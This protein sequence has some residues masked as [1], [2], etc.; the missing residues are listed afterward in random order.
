L[1]S[2]RTLDT[3]ASFLAGELRRLG[4]RVDEIRSLPDH[5]PVLIRTIRELARG[6][7][8]LILTGG[9]G[10]TEDDRTRHA[11]ALAA[12]KPLR[13]H[14]PSLTAIEERFR[15]SGRTMTANNRTQAMFPAS[16]SPLP[17]ARGTAPGIRMRLGSCRLLAFPGVPHE[18]KA[19]WE[20]S[21]LPLSRELGRR[22]LRLRRLHVF[23][24]TESEVDRRMH[25]L[26]LPGRD[27]EVGLT[28][29][30]SVITV[31]LTSASR[32]RIARDETLLRRLLGRA[33]FG[34]DGE[35]LAV[36]VARLLGRRR[37][38]LA[39]AESAT[40]GLIS[41]LLTEVPGASRI[42]LESR[43][44]YTEG[45]KRRLGVPAALLRKHGTVS[46]PVTRALASRIRQ[47]SGS[48][49]GLAAT[50]V[51]GPS[52]GSQTLPVGTCFLALAG[53]E[54]VRVAQPIFTGD[55]SQVKRRAALSALD[56]LRLSSGG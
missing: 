5:L 24:L 30:D 50:G 1:T 19:M 7:Q 51:A 43:T 4:G 55:R 37:Q 34:T 16:S 25:P 3:N 45:A 28:V 40:G 53:P 14:P 10:P 56:L 44:V 20:S 36:V 2:G 39:L 13:L 35:S 6:R 29:Q 23:G 31:T 27:P 8:L 21:S 32:T 17:N 18:M 52:G 33:L 9:L 42:L 54:G 41:H 12:G 47:V 11:L 22:A 26:M 38:T 48:T 49:W 46:E 15:R